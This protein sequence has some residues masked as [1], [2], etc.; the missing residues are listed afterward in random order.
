MRTT[1]LLL[2]VAL[3]VLSAC[4]L[5]GG[6][7]FTVM[8]SADDANVPEGLRS[9]YREDAVRLALR[10]LQETEHPDRHEV[11]VPDDAVQPFYDALIHVYNAEGLPARDS[12]VDLYRVHTFRYPELRSLVLNVYPDAPWLPAL[13]EG[14]RPVGEPK[15]DELLEEYDLEFVR[16]HDLVTFVYDL[17]VLRAREPLNV[18]ALAALF[19]GIDRLEGA[20]AN[21][22]VG[23][24]NDIRAGVEPESWLLHYSTGFGDCPAGCI[25]RY[26]WVFRVH[27]DGRVTYEGGHGEPP[28]PP[29]P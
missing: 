23:D 12:V 17:V 24:G 2:A 6:P 21:G 8:S 29:A 15:L 3:C 4:D 14:V 16:Y 27:T 20:W 1:S 25:S 28:P 26:H 10:H 18:A 5:L 13:R 22:A 7:D 11:R 19:V 9:A